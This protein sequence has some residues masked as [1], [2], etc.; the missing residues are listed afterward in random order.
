MIPR[1]ATKKL[2]ELATK[3]PIVSVIGPRQSGKTTLVRAAF[4]NYQYFSLETPDVRKRAEEDPRL[5]LESIVKNGVILD[6]VQRVPS[7]FSYLQTFVDENK[8]MGQCILTGSHNF[9]LLE[10]ISQ[11]LAGRVG[12]IQLLPLSLEELRQASLLPDSLYKILYSGMYPPIYDRDINPQD[13]YPNYIATYVERDVRMIKNIPDL[14]K[15]QT[16]LKLCAGRIVQVVNFSSLAADCGVSTNTV[17]SWISILEASFILFL[18]RPYYKNFNKRV[19]KQAKIYFYDTGLLCSLLGIQNPGQVETHYARGS[20]FESF[21][22][23]E[24]LKYNLDRGKKPE[25]Y[26]WRDHRGDEVDVIIEQGERLTAVEIKAGHTFSSDYFSALKRFQT[27][28]DVSK[29]AT[30]V[31]YSGS[32]SQEYSDGYLLSWKEMQKIF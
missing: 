31:I 15:F 12:F 28:A 29:D 18:L 14:S 30:F 16:L 19:T 23:S 26:F 2:L 20:I 11:T 1:I 3:F 9:L 32:E 21:I 6:E 25:I 5:F 17:K 27:T 4:P 8:K 7:L 13:W 24:I 10:Q 22:V